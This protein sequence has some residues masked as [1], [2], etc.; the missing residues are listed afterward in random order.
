MMQV[1]EVA[2]LSAAFVI[3]YIA[4]TLPAGRAHFAE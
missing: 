2:F 4:P 3:A 1:A